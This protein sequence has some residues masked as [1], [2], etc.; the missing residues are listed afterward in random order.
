M[1]IIVF[2]RPL[3]ADE[4][5]RIE[6]RLKL[7]DDARKK[8][9]D[10]GADP[11]EAAAEAFVKARWTKLQQSREASEMRKYAIING[12]FDADIGDN[13]INMAW[14]PLRYHRCHRRFLLGRTMGLPH[15][16][17]GRVLGP[18]HV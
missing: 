14:V 6:E 16:K 18:A 7:Y 1:G 11:R 9:L 15:G 2:G 8:L 5:R 10:E 3:S 4:Q 12:S 13:R 17:G